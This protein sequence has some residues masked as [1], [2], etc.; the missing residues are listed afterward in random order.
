[1]PVRLTNP[2]RKTLLSGGRAFG[3]MLTSVRWPGLME[4]LA[5]A[6]WNFVVIDTE[7]SLYNPESLEA[8]FRTARHAGIP[9]L[10]RPADADYHLIA[11]G[12]DIGAA[13][14]MVPHVDTVEETR[15]IALACR[16]PPLGE[17]G[18]GGNV[19]SMSGLPLTEFLSDA[20]EGVLAGIMIE[21]GEAVSRLDQ[22]AAVPGIDALVIGP[23]DLSIALG[24]PGKTDHPTF[25]EAADKVVAFAEKHKKAPGIHVGSPKECEFWAK[26]GFRWLMCSTETGM[27][28]GKSA[29]L[30]SA[31]KE[32]CAGKTP[33]TAVTGGG[34]PY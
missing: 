34:S 1:M 11:R 15:Q 24:I 5:E 19:V 21:S 32:I 6:G 27:L 16:F 9:A 12:L 28:R 33:T 13:G 23:T 22:M 4:L 3:T 17:R 10:L 26:R 20:N 18:A 2:A 7:H 25:L 14:L 30:A 31:M 29:E 8:M